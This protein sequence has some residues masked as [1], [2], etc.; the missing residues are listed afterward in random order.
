MAER[1]KPNN[2]EKYFYVNLQYGEPRRDTWLNADLDENR[3][4]N[5][6]CFKTKQEAEYA[7]NKVKDLLLSLHPEVATLPKL[8]AEIFDRPDCPK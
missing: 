4:E 3:W 5:G 2:G 6:D 8:T 7:A 1:W